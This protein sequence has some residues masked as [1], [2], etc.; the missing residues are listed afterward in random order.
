MEVFTSCMNKLTHK[1]FKAWTN[2]FSTLA[3]A[4]TVSRYI[5]E[6][7]KQQHLL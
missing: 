4:I 6:I 7:S 5:E 2:F 1:K 3:M